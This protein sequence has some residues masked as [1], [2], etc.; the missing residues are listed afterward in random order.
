[1]TLRPLAVCGLLIAAASGA[2]AIHFLARVPSTPAP[3]AVA[4]APASTVPSSAMPPRAAAAAASPAESTAPSAT[5][6]AP[7]RPESLA[8]AQ[9]AAGP[10]PMP[11]AR[12]RQDNMADLAKAAEAPQEVEEEKAELPDDGI[13]NIVVKAQRGDTLTRLL[14]DAGVPRTDA[15]AVADSIHRVFDPR[16]LKP[17]HEI[18]LSFQADSEPEAR[19]R[20][21]GRLQGLQLAAAIDREVLVRAMPD[22]GF[23]AEAL[24]KQVNR[25]MARSNGEIA[26]G[27]LL[28]AGMA[29]GVPAGVMTEMIRIF[30]FDVDFQ[31]DI[32]PGDRFDVMYE[33]FHLADGRLVRGGDVMYAALTLSGKTLRLYR[34]KNTQGHLDYYNELGH[35]V[36]KALLKTPIDG[37]RLT[38]R[39]G[40]R[41]HPILGYSV[42]HRGVD[43]GA[44]TGT[45]IYAAGDG[46][47][48][49][50]GERNGYGRYIRIRHS[51][52]YATAYAHMNAYGRGLKRGMRVRQGQVIGYVG[53]SGRVT[54]PHLHYEV[55]RDG[56]QINP[57]SVKFPT[58]EKLAGAELARF[59]SVRNELDRSLPAAQMALERPGVQEIG[60][61]R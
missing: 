12:P 44:P 15:Q 31:R 41:E 36:R 16:D 53:A 27:S 40:M 50:L 3:S 59:Q 47:I 45:P 18:Q 58:G 8:L 20:S 24:V 54:G 33:R 43:F 1:M 35:S 60:A 7:P 19:A 4:A 6:A 9:P 32:Q 29:S 56:A 49:D 22:G 37:A 14:V 26:G 5:P 25:A 55:L 28:A 39:F 34:Y 61:G 51:G 52:T 2:F 48:D 42:M 11:S 23:V 10:H 21:L 57:V 17:G 46:T 13:T 30:S 38:S